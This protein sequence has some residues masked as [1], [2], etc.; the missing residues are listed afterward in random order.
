MIQQFGMRRRGHRTPEIAGGQGRGRSDIENAAA[1]LALLLGTAAI[2]V[3]LVL[4]AHWIAGQI[5]IVG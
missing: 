5:A 1:G 3:L 4:A 2:F